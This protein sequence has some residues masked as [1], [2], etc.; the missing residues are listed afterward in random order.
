MIV[1]G[2]LN[3]RLQEPWQVVLIALFA[4]CIF[5]S[6]I[7]ACVFK[8]E[9]EKLDAARAQKRQADEAAAAAESAAAE[10]AKENERDEKLAY[11]THLVLQVAPPSVF[12]TRRLSA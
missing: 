3:V 9:S 6:C 1:L 2:L 8:G 11:L 5:I 12:G 7:S 10:R 4:C